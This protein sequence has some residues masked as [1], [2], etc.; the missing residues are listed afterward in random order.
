[1]SDVK[2]PLEIDVT[3]VGKVASEPNNSGGNSESSQGSKVNEQIIPGTTRQELLPFY[4]DPIISENNQLFSFR[5]RDIVSSIY[6][7]SACKINLIP[8]DRGE[9]DKDL[10]M[11][12]LVSK[13]LLNRE[14]DA[15]VNKEALLN[16]IPAIQIRE[17]TQDTKL[18][19]LWG[20]L[21]QAIQGFK[22][23]SGAANEEAEKWLAGQG[24]E[25]NVYKFSNRVKWLGQY[26]CDKIKSE[27]WWNDL[28]SFLGTWFSG[29]APQFYSSQE[30]EG[31]PEDKKITLA[32]KAVYCLYYRMIGAT[33]TNRYV[34]PYSGQEIF[35]TNGTDGWPGGISHGNIGSGNSSFVGTL[36]NFALGSNFK[37]VTEPIW[38]G[39]SGG[40][41]GGITVTFSLYNDTKEH[42]I[43]NFIFVNTICPSNLFLQYGIWQLPPSVYDVK[44]EG[45]RRWY[46]CKGSMQCTYKG[47][48]RDL[49]MDLIKILMEKHANK[50]IQNWKDYI[51]SKES[52]VLKIPDVYELTLTFNSLLPDNFNQF[53]F[54]YIGNYDIAHDITENHMDLATREEPW[55]TEGGKVDEFL[56]K[57]LKE[58]AD[59]AA[60]QP[61]YD[62]N[63]PQSKVTE[64]AKKEA[65]TGTTTEGGTK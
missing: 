52:K 18:D 47:V 7:R 46:M 36:L 45:G 26:I 4:I 25:E 63:D 16:H 34:I 27:S 2:K 31:T 50:N 14:G 12:L 3:G 35:N 11:Q 37:I 57:T 24:I 28:I 21:K 33:T 62:P 5:N 9:F 53:L 58:A 41:G 59:E 60:K 43:N 10:G 17:Y 38:Q 32:V 8:D 20:I 54:Q 61:E 44:I 56:K 19:L 29:N 55:Y 64:D 39:S 40:E 51:N 6:D 65:A 23:G 42:A 48:M 13:Y 49:P 15:Q 1:M 30:E 22:D